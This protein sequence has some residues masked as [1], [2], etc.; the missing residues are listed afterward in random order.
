MESILRRALRLV[1]KDKHLS[2]DDMLVRSN[3]IRL[4]LARLHST[5]IETF[6]CMKGLNTEYMSHLFIPN[7]NC[8]QTGQHCASC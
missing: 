3:M 6:K 4:S 2:Y 8:I 1:Y 5:A 7:S